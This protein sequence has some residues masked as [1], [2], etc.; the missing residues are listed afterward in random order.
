FLEKAYHLLSAIG[1]ASF[2]LPHRFFKTDYG[3]GLRKFLSTNKSITKIVDFDGFMV[4]KDAS[5]NTC[6]ILLS[7]SPKD[8]YKFAQIKFIRKPDSELPKFLEKIDLI[9]ELFDKDLIISNLSTKEFNENPWIFIFSNEK[10]IWKKFTSNKTRLGDIS[11]QIFQGLKTGSDAIFSIKIIHQFDNYSEIECP[12]DNNIYKIEND[13]LYPQ[14]KGGD[15]KRYFVNETNKAVIF[16]YKNG[17]LIEKKEF[18]KSF[19]LTWKYLLTHKYYLEK[20]EGGKMKGDSWYGYTRTQALSSMQQKKIL[21]PEYYADA[22]YCIDQQG[23]YFFFGG[24]AG[25]YGIVINDINNFYILGLL[26]SK[27]IDWGLQKISVRQYQTAFSYVKKY[28]EQIPIIS[29]DNSDSGK[30]NLYNQIIAL[31]ERMLELHKRDPQTPQE[32]DRIQRE[33]AATD[34]AIDKLVYE[35]YGLTEEEVRIVEG[36]S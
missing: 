27:L 2:I 4:F 14:V 9:D 5:I 7:K 30:I 22:S 21:T 33:I 20:R 3:E 32:A 36:A 15:M 12:F 31:V 19:P 18:E 23:K 29:I 34:A 10:D 11:S 16:P 1:Y 26:N 13:L 25:G 35:L 6:V 28:I 24:G 8:N 17:K